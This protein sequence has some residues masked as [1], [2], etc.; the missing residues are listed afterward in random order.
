MLACSFV[1]LIVPWFIMLWSVYLWRALRSKV[2]RAIARLAGVASS[3][4]YSKS[5]PYSRE[6]R[7][8]QASRYPARYLRPALND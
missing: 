3:E 6:W 7:R 8:P 4:V 5:A 1:L 2:S